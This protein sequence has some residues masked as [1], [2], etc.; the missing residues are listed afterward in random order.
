MRPLGEFHACYALGGMRG[1]FTE[2]DTAHLLGTDEAIPVVT[3]KAV[4]TCK[5]L[6]S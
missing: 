6:I 1:D 2:S 5:D 3:A 4:P